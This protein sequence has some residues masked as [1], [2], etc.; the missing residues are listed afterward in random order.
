LQQ[1]FGSLQRNEGGFGRPFCCKHHVGRRRVRSVGRLWRHNPSMKSLANSVRT[2]V[3][4]AL[5]LV[6][7][8][9]SAQSP[10]VYYVCPG[11]V[12]TNT[13]TPKE[14][15]T[16]GCKSREAQ[17]PTTITG[18]KVRAAAGGATASGPKSE[19]VDSAEQRARDS[20][21]RRI[22]QEEL[23]RAEERL[24]EMQREFNNGEPGRRGDEIR[25]NQKYIDRVA[26]MKAAITRQEADVAAI[27][28][29]LAKLPS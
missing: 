3:A 22:L 15:E 20:D 10:S 16:R 27:K 19:K 11:N 26:E 29:E 4:P 28:R 1:G 8:A 25:N 23:R 5:L 18:P 9:A 21:A 24:E 6:V 13:I 14:A 12:F 17:Q 7:A 2:V